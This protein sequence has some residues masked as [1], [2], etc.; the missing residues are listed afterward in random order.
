MLHPS[1]HAITGLLSPQFCLE[2]LEDR[3]LLAA[4]VP[5][6]LD[7][8]SVP[9]YVNPMP[10]ALDPS[11]IYQPVSGTQTQYDI[12]VYPIAQD[13]G[14]GPINPVTGQQTPVLTKLYGY[15]T[16]AST[17]TY[18]GR[19]F[20]AE[21]GTPVS[22]KWRNELW[23]SAG[24][25]IS[26]DDY[27]VRTFNS[28]GENV[29]A[30]DHSLF[31][32]D[33]MPMQGIPVVTHLH[34]G[35]TESASDG[36]PEQW[37]TP[38]L[39]WGA[40][41]E[42]GPDYVKDVF[43]YDNDQRAA[44]LWYHDHAMGTTRLAAYAGQAGFYIIRDAFDTGNANNAWGL[45]AGAYE[46]PIAIQDKTFTAS[47]ELFY[48]STSV[49]DPDSDNDIDPSTLPEM[50]GDTIVVNGKAWPFLNVEPRTYRFHLLNGSDSRFYNFFIPA[51]GSPNANVPIVQIGGD[52]GIFNTAVTLNSLL[53]APG[54]RA[55]VIINFTGLQGQSLVLR[56]NAKT[57]YP[58]GETVNPQTTG[59]IM[60]FRV[61]TTVTTPASPIPTTLR[62]G[63]GQPAWIDPLTATTDPVTGQAKVR[64][65]GLFEIMDQYGRITP[66]LGTVGSA[67]DGPKGFM[68]PVTETPF[69]NDTE[70][71]EVYNTTADSHPIHLHLVS[72]QIINHQKFNFALD[73]ET[74][75]VVPGSIRFTGKPMSSPANEQG[76]ED[77]VI[78]NPGEVTRIIARYDRLG[79]YVWH[80]HI[81]SHEEHD[82]MRPMEV[83]APPTKTLTALSTPASTSD[84]A[85][86]AP[87]ATNAF[88]TASRPLVRLIDET[89]ASEGQLPL[90]L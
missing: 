84:L 45:P 1:L 58:K 68:E 16:S 59:Q 77:T 18:P 69:L 6:L 79:K 21:S 27:V 43:T 51:A 8:L 4:V 75:G 33:H 56:N 67:T 89:T 2:Q 11:F 76:W 54:E 74:N 20:V 44:A 7:P 23:T 47:G 38:P 39:A 13:L 64:K 37:Y 17:A 65:V 30:V 49:Q 88:A 9:K 14:L 34:G 62:G 63:P 53:L 66:M 61:G 10:N 3:R 86:P 85:A 55:D 31:D 40:P 57:P 81:L 35:H 83:I 87:F 32:M 80:C 19:T 36:T 41:V 82:M 48:P 22:I 90:Y 46:I 12:G 71:W 50:F 15:G 26:L 24:V 72:F 73:P 25:P 60:Q 5:G 42:T 52:Q 70:I 29:S 78:M 28:D